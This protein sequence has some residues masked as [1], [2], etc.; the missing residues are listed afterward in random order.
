MY[1]YHFDSIIRIF[2]V[3]W[4]DLV[5][6]SMACARTVRCSLKLTL[7]F[8]KVNLTHDSFNCKWERVKQT[9]TKEVANVKHFGISIATFFILISW[10]FVQICVLCR[11]DL[12][13]SRLESFCLNIDPARSQHE[14]ESSQIAMCECHYPFLSCVRVRNTTVELNTIKSHRRCWTTHSSS[15]YEICLNEK[16]KW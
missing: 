9:E 1:A 4:F 7:S 3:I 15:R 10:C 12:F 8:P 13:L 2:N 5:F 6:L 11:F 14:V 16:Q